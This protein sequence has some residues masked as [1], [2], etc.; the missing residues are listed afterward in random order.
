MGKVFSVGTAGYIPYPLVSSPDPP[1]LLDCTYLTPILN[2][3]VPGSSIVTPGVILASAAATKL[4]HLSSMP[5]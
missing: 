1:P 3:A 2:L 5:T 4:V